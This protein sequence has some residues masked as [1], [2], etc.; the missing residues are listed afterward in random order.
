M[1]DVSFLKLCVPTGRWPAKR[2]RS[3]LETEC[4]RNGAHRIY[5]FHRNWDSGLCPI[6]GCLGLQ[7]WGLLLFARSRFDRASVFADFDNVGFLGFAVLV[8]MAV[9]AEFVF[10]GFYLFP[11]FRFCAVSRNCRFLGSRDFGNPWNS[12]FGNCHRLR[13][14]L[15]WGFLGFG[16]CGTRVCAIC[17][18]GD[19]C[20]FWILGLL[21]FS[22]GAPFSCA[23]CAPICSSIPQGGGRFLL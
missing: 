2:P 22:S 12:R 7:I 17:Q 3:C 4:P 19:F 1:L 21:G 18:F 10:L 20:D 16:S 8:R 5:L 11:E 23:R 15:S 13:G 6:W 9:S 14:L